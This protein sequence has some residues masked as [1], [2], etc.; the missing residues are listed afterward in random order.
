MHTSKPELLMLLWLCFVVVLDVLPR[1]LQT[2]GR[3]FWLLLELLPKVTR[4]RRK[5]SFRRQEDLA[6][7]QA[8]AA[9]FQRV[10]GQ[11]LRCAQN[12]RG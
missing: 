3:L 5:T 11:I 2:P 6:R 12:D 1:C 9:Q 4:R 8:H 7:A 10:C